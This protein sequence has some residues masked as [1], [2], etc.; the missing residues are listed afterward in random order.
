MRMM[1]YGI[2]LAWVLLLGCDQQASIGE[3]GDAAAMTHG[4][5]GSVAGCN[6]PTCGNYVFP[7]SPRLVRVVSQTAGDDPWNVLE[8]QYNAAGEII[9]GNTLIGGYRMI[10]ERY[11]YEGGRLAKIESFRGDV[12][13]AETVLFWDGDSYIGEDYWSDGRVLYDDS[14]P[15]GRQPIHRSRRLTFGAFGVESIEHQLTFANGNTHMRILPI[16]YVESGMVDR[17]NYPWEEGGSELFYTSDRI[18]RIRSRRNSTVSETQFTYDANGRLASAEAGTMTYTYFYNASGLISR[19]ES[20]QEGRPDDTL[21]LTYEMGTAPSIQFAHAWFVT[22][23]GE[24]TPMVSFT[25]HVIPIDSG[26][27]WL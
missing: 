12:Q 17:W 26:I 1:K 3:R 14:D 7:P 24:V 19:I 6:L 8:L 18:S 16:T 4:S 11:T 23:R 10:R 13:G 5:D 20:Q 15:E 27:S 2:G 9:G 25:S 22:L 21:E